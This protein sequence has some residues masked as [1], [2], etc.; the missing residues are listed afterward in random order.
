M[1]GHS[2]WA[3]IQHRKGAQD[4]K[5][6]NLFT[7]LAKEITIAAKLGDSNPDFNPRLRLAVAA[8]KKLSMPNDNI[9]RAIDKA[10]AAGGGDDSITYEGYGPNQVAIMVETLTD[11]KNRTFS[12]IRAIFGKN[13]GNLG[14][15]G[16]VAFNFERQGLI[17]YKNDIA[18]FDT[19]FEAVVEAGAENMEE[20]EGMYIITCEVNEL[21]NV[22][23]ALEEKFKGVDPEKCAPAWMPKMT[24]ELDDEGHEKLAAFIEKIEENDDVQNVFHNAI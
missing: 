1:A 14:S 23:K 6:G 12:E 19:M 3:N 16:S 17:I 18:D 10:S 15:E 4:K 13:G 22:F 9:K 5:R 20:E 8:A 11:N 21:H 24:V 2:K 7:K